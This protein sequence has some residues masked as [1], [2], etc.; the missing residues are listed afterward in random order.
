MAVLVSFAGAAA[1]NA[2]TIIAID[3]PSTVGVDLVLNDDDGDGFI[4]PPAITNPDG[5]LATAAFGSS[6]DMRMGFGALVG[7]LDDAATLNF[8]F[9]QTGFSGSG[10][11]I[12]SL[13]G[14]TTGI[15]GYAAFYDPG[16]APFALTNLIGVT[17]TF[18]P[19]DLGFNT[20]HPVSGTS[21]SMTQV[22]SV[23]H[24][25]GRQLNGTGF[26]ASLEVAPTVVPEPATMTLFGLGVAA[27]GLARRRTRARD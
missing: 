27:A 25:G 26:T 14:E 4:V 13:F 9:T 15:V 6:T 3:D 10:E 2:A 22:V 16:N 5:F 23:Q 19:G 12:A 11:A 1:A 18:G 17:G 24:Q 20:S 21:Y 8:Y 7:S